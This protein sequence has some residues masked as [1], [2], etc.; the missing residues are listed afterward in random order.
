VVDLN[1]LSDLK[2]HRRRARAWFQIR[3]GALS[4]SEHANDRFKKAVNSALILC[5][6]AA[7][8]AIFGVRTGL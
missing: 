6:W 4:R 7:F 3:S 8:P 2:P 1:A 5:V